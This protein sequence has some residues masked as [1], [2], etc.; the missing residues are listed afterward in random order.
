VN[1]L[2]WLIIVIIALSAFQGMRRGLLASLTG[3]AGTLVGLF[4]AYTYYRPLEQYL[5]MNWNVGEKIKPLVMQ[6]F[7]I[8]IPSQSI[9]S[10]AQPGKLIS[11]GGAAIGKVPNISDYLANSFTSVVLESLCFLALLWATTWAVNLVGF[12]LTKAA[13]FSL[14]GGPNHLGGLLFGTVRGLA[15]VVIILALLTPFQNA[16]SLPD[17]KPGTGTTQRRSSAFESSKLLPYF[18]PLFG[19]LGRQLPISPTMPLKDPGGARDI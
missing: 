17:S 1:W 7:K 19:A 14:L 3:L 13:Q 16:A 12:V 9:Q 15:V 6:L 11:A 5:V 18:E 4:V 8:W 2:D 10:A